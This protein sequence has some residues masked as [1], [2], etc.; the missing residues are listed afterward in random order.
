MP[1]YLGGPS[2]G[3][4]KVIFVPCINKAIIIEHIKQISTITEK[5]CHAIIIMDSAGWHTTDIAKQ[6]SSFSLY[7]LRATPNRTG[8]ELAQTVLPRPELYRLLDIASKM[9]GAW[10]RFLEST[11]RIMKICS[12][13]WINLTINF[14]DFYNQKMSIKL[15]AIQKD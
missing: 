7:S 3:I 10:N 11:D 13:N 8:V 14:S 1:I 9:Y 15:M 4:G 12:R 6:F 2:R 5:G